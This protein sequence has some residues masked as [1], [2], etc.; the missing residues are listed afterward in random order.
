MQW[1]KGQ[2]P[3]SIS[4]DPRTS[5]CE[6]FWESGVFEAK[7]KNLHIKSW[8]V[9]VCSQSIDKCLCERRGRQTDI[10]TQGQTLSLGLTVP[11][12]L[13]SQLGPCKPPVF[14]SK[15]C[16]VPGPSCHGQYGTPTLGLHGRSIQATPFQI[17]CNCCG[18]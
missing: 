8:W 18:K 16:W 12:R 4:S 11:A 14:H 1:V 10:E 7:I 6:L 17:C 5:E 9:A 15:Q 13:A 3:F 2:P